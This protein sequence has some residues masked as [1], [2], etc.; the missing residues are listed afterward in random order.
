MLVFIK[1][2]C[3]PVF[4]ADPA[5]LRASNNLTVSALY[6]GK[7]TI[8]DHMKEVAATIW[9]EDGGIEDVSLTEGSPETPLLCKL[10]TKKAPDR[11]V[12]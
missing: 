11:C 3:L 10:K 5:L 1:K 9:E 8:F 2:H 7:E 12:S 4:V 6:T